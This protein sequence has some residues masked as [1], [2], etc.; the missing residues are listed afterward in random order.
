MSNATTDTLPGSAAPKQPGFILTC[1][2]N[3]L[4]GGI[5]YWLWV[6]L[7]LTGVA[8]G[9]FFYLGQVR[10]GLMIT[11]LSDQVS[12]GFYIANFAFLVGIAASA[13]LL[14][15]P[16]YIFHRKEMKNVVLLGEAVAVAAVVTAM[17]FVTLDLGR[18]DRLW[19]LLP[20]IGEFNFPISLLAWDVTVLSG[21]LLLNLLIPLYVLHCHFKGREPTFWAYFPWV[22]LAMFWAISIHT[23][24][25]FLFAANS[26]RPFWDTALLA[27]RFI[28][29]AFVS[30]P[31]LM[32]IA[33]QII[34]KV[35]DYPISQDVIRMLAVIMTVALQISLFFLITEL[36]VD[37]YN[38]GAHAASAR[39]LFFG[40]YGFDSLTMWIWTG[41]FLNIA[42]VLILMINP[43][44]ENLITLNLACILAFVGIWIEKGMGLV[45]TGFI[46]TPLGEIMEYTPT[47]PELFISLGAWSLG[48]LVFTLLVKMII[49]IELGY[50]QRKPSA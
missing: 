11:G 45:V 36:F 23:V 22:V 27:P 42:A 49:P 28:A 14:V 1:L 41:I 47:V 35:T 34:R 43:L 30:G 5:A 10:D 32:I 21:Y 18:P 29:S 26:A 15:I 4:K 13:V 25:A 8:T 6:F 24:T 38:E 12:W 17:T 9:A 37:F 20:L 44:R 48:V 2:G 33:L 16:A 40:L 50:R 31:A 3:L 39:Y 7:L 46:P 19:H